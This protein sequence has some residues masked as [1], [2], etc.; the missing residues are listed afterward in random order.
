MCRIRATE[1]KGDESSGLKGSTQVA[2]DPLSHCW[3][4]MSVAELAVLLKRTPGEVG[5]MADKLG[6]GRK[7]S[8]PWSEAEMDIIHKHYAQGVE[9][10]ELTRLLP[11]R[12]VSAIFSRAEAHYRCNRAG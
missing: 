11:G 3:L 6:C 5:L 12:S 8:T 2:E 10:V 7:G 1:A 4:Q 9:A